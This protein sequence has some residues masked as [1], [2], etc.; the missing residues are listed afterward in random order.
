LTWT[1]F[2]GGGTA[3]MLEVLD[4]YEQAENLRI[5]HIQQ[6]FAARSAAAQAAQIFGPTQ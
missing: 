6:D 4:A 3:T 1:R 5:N 2:L